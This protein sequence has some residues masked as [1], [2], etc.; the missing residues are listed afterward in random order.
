MSLQ[1]VTVCALSVQQV[2]ADDN[3][4][5]LIALARE[6]EAAGALG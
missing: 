3:A 5:A 6:H 4:D 2:S 1:K